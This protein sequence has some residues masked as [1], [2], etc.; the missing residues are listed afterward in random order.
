MRL[1]R[2]V[3][4]EVVQCAIG[5]FTSI[6]ST[7]VHAL[8]F[9]VATAGAL[10]LLGARDGDEGVDLRERVGLLLHVRISLVLGIMNTN[11]SRS[12]PGR[13]RRGCRRHG[14][15]GRRMGAVGRDGVRVR[16]TILAP[17]GATVHASLA[18]VPGVGLCHVVLRR[19]GRVL[20]WRRVGRAGGGDGRIYR[21]VGVRFHAVRVLMATWVPI[22]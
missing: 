12:S 21:K 17:F 16:L 14:G 4:I 6:P 10:V 11:L 19:V 3:G 22:C 8:D 7:F 1:H 20:A 18:G 2:N 13:G 15:R 9:L 5:L